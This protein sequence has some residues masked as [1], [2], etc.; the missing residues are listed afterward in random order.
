[1]IDSSLDISNSYWLKNTQSLEYR[2][3]QALELI[4]AE[5]GSVLDFG[6]GD[7][8]LLTCL[9]SR[10]IQCVG[11]DA[12]RVAVDACISKGLHVQLYVADKNLPVVDAY[13]FVCLDVLEHMF[14]P[15]VLLREAHNQYKELI[16]SVPNFSSLPARLQ[17][18]LGRVPENNTPRKGHVY[19]FT[20]TVLL[21][22][23]QKSGWEL[24]DL[25]GNVWLESVPILGK[26][27]KYCSN[28]WPSGLYL[29]FV[30][31]AKR[32]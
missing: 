2:H 30:V 10:G 29:S 14:D 9:K 3:K 6:C 15:L 8:L 5:K 28:F 17:V 21:N 25:R 12:S 22:M 24:T 1:M 20:Y 11:L 4:D 27:I 18:L 26:L 23:L 13:T 19:W 7:G 31:K 16:I 32:V